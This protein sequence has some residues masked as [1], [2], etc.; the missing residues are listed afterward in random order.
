MWQSVQHYLKALI[1]HSASLSEAKLAI[2]IVTS[3]VLN[4]ISLQ[5]LQVL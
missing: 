3:D 5:K 1:N 2:I 4:S